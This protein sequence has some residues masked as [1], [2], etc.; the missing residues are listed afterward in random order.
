[1]SGNP[2]STRTPSIRP[3][4]A[5]RESRPTPR[6][7]QEVFRNAFIIACITLNAYNG[8]MAIL[9]IRRLSDDVHARLRVRAARAGRSMEAEAREILARACAGTNDAPGGSSEVRDA[10]GSSHSLNLT[11]GQLHSAQRHAERRGTTLE[12][13]LRQLLERELAD[14]DAGRWSD[15]LFG[16]MAAAGGDSG[17]ATWTRDELHRV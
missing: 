15:D 14:N 9:N 16:R 6:L 12:D 2:V 8:G 17:G 11:P 5:L 13:L 4:R 3:A 1:M 7:Q 10:A